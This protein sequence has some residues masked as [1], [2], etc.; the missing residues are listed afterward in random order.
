MRVLWADKTVSKSGT[1][2]PT[3]LRNRRVRKRLQRAFDEVKSL[4]E[5]NM[6]VTTITKVIAD[7]IA[8]QRSQTFS[9]R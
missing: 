4:I 1:S 3:D 7:E 9:A 2:A 6:I 5:G 8:D